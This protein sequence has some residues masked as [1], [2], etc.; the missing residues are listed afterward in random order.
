MHVPEYRSQQY[1]ERFEL[2]KIYHGTE[3]S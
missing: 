3:P 1:L 2:T